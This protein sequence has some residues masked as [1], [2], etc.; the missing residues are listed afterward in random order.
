M[1]I[2][3]WHQTRNRPM[4][5]TSLAMWQMMAWFHNF[6]ACKKSK[7][8]LKGGKKAQCASN[9]WKD[10][11]YLCTVPVKSKLQH[12]PPEAKKLFK[13]TI[14]GP[15]QVIKCPHPGKLFGS[16]YYAFIML[17]M[18]SDQMPAPGESKLIKFPPSRAGKD[19][20]CL[21]YARG[22]G[23]ECL[24][25]DLTGTLNEKIIWGLWAI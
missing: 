14:I 13:C 2:S 1:Q 11:I 3:L 15:F 4:P 12:P 5:L 8:G 10:K 24:S 25:F 6:T 19:V 7:F 23:G 16:F 20:K 17:P 21:G 22:G 18:S 9:R